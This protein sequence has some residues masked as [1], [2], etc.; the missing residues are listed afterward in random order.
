MSRSEVDYGP[1]WQAAHRWAHGPARAALGVIFERYGTPG[2]MLDVGCGEGA[3]CK[4]AS[5]LGVRS[6]G[7]DIGLADEIETDERYC[8][9]KAD[10]RK[11]RQLGE[12][13]QMVVCWEVAEHLPA[14]AAATLVETIVGHTGRRL[15]FSAAVP[16]QGGHGHIN[17]QPHT[18]WRGLLEKAGLVYQANETTGLRL[19]LEPVVKG[20]W[21]YARNMMVFEVAP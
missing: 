8:L 17:E 9:I 2:T 21:W 19:A 15:F 5:A 3:L 6:V 4:M 18:Y 7:L 11:P 16:G 10:L 1:A 13:F 14:E 20:A 12:L